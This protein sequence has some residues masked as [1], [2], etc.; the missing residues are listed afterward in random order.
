MRASRSVGGRRAGRAALALAALAAAGPAGAQPV[1][2]RR[3]GGTPVLA[4]ALSRR[5]PG[6]RVLELT[7]DLPADTALLAREARDADVLFAVGPDATAAAGDAGGPAVVALAVAN[8][9]Q[10]RTAGTY[11][12]VYPALDGVFAYV[13]GTL[14]AGRAGVLFSPARNREVGVQFLRAGAAHGV[15][16]VPVTVSSSGDLVRALRATLP[17]LDVLLLAVDP[18]LFDAASLEIIVAEARAA[19]KPAVGFLEDL[20]RLGVP[21]AL[22]ANAEAAAALAVGA[23]GDPVRVGKRRVEVAGAEVVVSRAAAAAI[24]LDPAALGAH[25]AH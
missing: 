21:V 3:A 18:V 8:P 9:A 5:L 16:V 24:G 17:E 7:G 13:K 15:A 19:R 22:V 12:S 6:A 23:S 11:V 1:I 20:T 4:D 2:V 14:R 10:V 25:R